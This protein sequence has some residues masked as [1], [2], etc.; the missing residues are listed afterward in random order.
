VLGR[1]FRRAAAAA[2]A[3]LA[4]LSLGVLAATPARQFESLIP[5]R[6]IDVAAAMAEKNPAIHV[7]GDDWSGSPMLWLHPAM[8]GRVAFD[9]RFEQYSPSEL[10]SFA[11]FVWVNGPRWQRVMRGYD[12]VVVSCRERP[13]LAAA[14]AQLPGWRVVYADHDGLV[15]ERQART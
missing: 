2:L 6:A 12:L 7:L 8:F 10:S 15:L 9:A 11:D 13:K 14:L 1:A 3:A 5:R 4:A